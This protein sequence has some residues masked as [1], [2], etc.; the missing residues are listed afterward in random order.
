VGLKLNGTHQLLVYDYEVNLLDDDIENINKNTETLIDAS[1]EVGLQ[2]KAK[3]TNYKLLARH[4]SAGQ[5]FD[6]KRANRSFENVAQLKYLGTTATNQNL[7]LKEIKRRMNSGNVC[8]HSVQNHLSSSLLSINVKIRIYKTII[9]ALVS[10]GCE[11][12]SLT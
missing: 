10:Y 4:Q 12:L 1:R 9:M 11:T 8:W 7:I 3:K 2:V 6:K 5:N